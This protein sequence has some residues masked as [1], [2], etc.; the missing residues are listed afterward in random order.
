MTDG[1]VVQASCQNGHVA[2]FSGLRLLARDVEGPGVGLRVDEEDTG[3]VVSVGRMAARREAAR[4]EAA[5]REAEE[6][7][8]FEEAVDVADV[9]E[10]VFRGH[11]P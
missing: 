2:M 9:A 6:E 3:E 7:E 4:R 8:E 11:I 5:R 10:K 1:L